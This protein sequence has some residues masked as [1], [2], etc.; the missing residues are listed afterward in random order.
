MLENILFSLD[1]VMPYFLLIA[2]GI[3]L[4][5]CKAVP[6]S[7]FEGANRFTFRVAL[8]LQLFCTIADMELRGGSTGYF[9][10]FVLLATVISFIVI[11]ALTEIIYRNKKHMI[12]T[13]VQGAFRGNFVLLGVPLAGSVLGQG[14]MQ[15]AAVASAVVVPAYNAL[16]VVALSVR[17]KSEKKP[18]VLD[19]LSDIIKNPLIIGI[20]LAVPFILTGLRLPAMLDTTARFVGQTATPL[21]LLSVGGMLNLADATARLRPAIYACV[22]KNLLLPVCVMSTGLFAGYRGA[23]LLVLLV[24]SAS[25]VAIS[26][27]AMAVEMGGDGPL[28]SNILILTTFVSGFVLAAGIYLLKTFAL[29]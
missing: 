13:L 4:R 3:G 24:L 18:S 8:P 7:F 2:L 1:R 17:G 26:S 15:V 10:L 6:R 20:A 28:A 22:I 29:I 25:P 21:G 19:V 23:E 16:S 27:Y 14:A 5:V 9:M 11:W 12:G